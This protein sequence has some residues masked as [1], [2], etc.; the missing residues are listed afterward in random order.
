MHTQHMA[1]VV[2]EGGNSTEVAAALGKTLDMLGASS[3]K[4]ILY[5]LED[6]YGVGTDATAEE[7]EVA[8]KSLLGPAAALVIA[9]MRRHLGQSS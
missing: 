8:L 7:A 4:V 1:Y 5:H 3:K 9:S 2:K 6:R